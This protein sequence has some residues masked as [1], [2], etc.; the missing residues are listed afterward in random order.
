MPSRSG[1]A[2]GRRLAAMRKTHGGGRPKIKTRCPKCRTICASA[3]EAK[4]HCRKTN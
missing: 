4:A 3:R 2:A 1:S